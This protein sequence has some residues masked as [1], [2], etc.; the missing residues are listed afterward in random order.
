M[1]ESFQLKKPRESQHQYYIVIGV[2]PR[3]VLAEHYMLGLHGRVD[4]Q[5]S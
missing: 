1:V 4:P 3:L 2:H 5:A